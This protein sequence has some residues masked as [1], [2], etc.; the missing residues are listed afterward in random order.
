MCV[1]VCVYAAA[2]AFLSLQ[3][4]H[5]NVYHP[6]LYAHKLSLYMSCN[7]LYNIVWASTAAAVC[8]RAWTF[9]L[10]FM[11]VRFTLTSSSLDFGMHIGHI[12]YNICMC[13]IL[14]STRV[15]FNSQVAVITA[16]RRE[17]RQPASRTLLRYRES[18]LLFTYMNACV[19]CTDIDGWM[20]GWL[21]GWMDG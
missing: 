8:V 3:I 11:F 10:L 4:F 1:C 6:Q 18:L 13:T 14:C 21:V 12:A 2:I 19:Y 5:L 9:L 7:V 20:V 17:G 15:D 16:V